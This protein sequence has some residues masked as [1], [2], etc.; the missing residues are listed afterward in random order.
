MKAYRRKEEEGVSPVI[1]TIL[2][3]AITV[4]L[5]A[6]LYLMV[7]QMGGQQNSPVA[8]SLSYV[9]TVSDPANGNA[10]FEVILNTPSN[11]KIGDVT[12]KVLDANGQPTSLSVV[13]SGT[14]IHILHITSDND[15]L[16][17]GDRIQIEAGNGVDIHGYQLIISI[18]GYSGTISGTVPS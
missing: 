10:T 5:A 8:G 15:H 1:A 17:S 16:K 18:A 13:A 12:I 6:T 9:S 7:G 14:G 11:P 2:M 4:V 3:V